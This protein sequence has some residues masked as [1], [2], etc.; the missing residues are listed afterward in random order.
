MPLSFTRG[1]QNFGIR[2]GFCGCNRSFLCKGL[3][4]LFVPANVPGS[5]KGGEEKGRD[6]EHENYVK[7]THRGRLIL[8]FLDHKRSR[9]E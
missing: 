9:R 3:S 1:N 8:Q 6:T 2:R 7:D 4:F 5:G